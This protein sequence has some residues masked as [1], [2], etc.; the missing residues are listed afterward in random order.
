MVIGA[1][2]LTFIERAKI[3]SKDLPQAGYFDIMRRKYSDRQGRVSAHMLK[4]DESIFVNTP[5]R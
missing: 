1:C 3:K 5:S 2:S 4:F